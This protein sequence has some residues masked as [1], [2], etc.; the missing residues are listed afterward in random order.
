[1]ETRRRRSLLLVG[2]AYV[3][4]ITLGLSGGLI[5][6]A[7]PSIRESF[8]LS[9]DALGA[10]LIAS[11]AGSL[12]SSF[13]SGRIAIRFGVG[14]L[15]LIGTLVKSLG[16]LGYAVAPGWWLMVLL[17]VLVGGG[18]GAIDAGT[19]AYFATNHSTRLMNWLHASFGVGATLG[20]AIMTGVLSLGQSW[21]WGYAIAAVIQGALV[22]LFFVTRNAWETAGPGIVET[23]PDSLSKKVTSWDMLNLPTVWLGIVLFFIYAGVEIT[24]GQWAFSLF[25]EARSIAVS[26]AGFWVSFYWGSFTAGRVLFGIVADRLRLV[27][28]LRLCMLG[29]IIASLLIWL[30][31]INAVS[32]L[33]LSLMGVAL[34]PIFPLLISATP[35]RVGARNATSVIGFQVGAAG[36]GIGVLPAF[37]GVLAERISLEVLGPYL[38]VTCIIMIVLH[39]RIVPLAQEGGR[40]L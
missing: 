12:I 3:N 18:G 20:P 7:W 29:A 2:F 25:T 14:W 5:G 22:V 38:L 27:T 26:T 33:G 17:A 28:M 34:A 10:L 40:T 31:S 16:L 39:E 36:L 19:N 4:F 13:N 23:N 1:M 11:T 37:A 32:F 24:A 6:V 30:R 35:K 8:N 9:L 21:R 15:L